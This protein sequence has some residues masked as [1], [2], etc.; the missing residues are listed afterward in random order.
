M[1]VSV[2]TTVESYPISESDSANKID[3]VSHLDSRRCCK[4]PLAEAE[5]W[6][7]YVI[8][9]NTDMEL[10]WLLIKLNY[11]E[12]ERA[13]ERSTVLF[14]PDKVHS[15]EIIIQWSVELSR[16]RETGLN[17]LKLL[18]WNCSGVT[19]FTFIKSIN[20]SH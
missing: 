16:R 6:S 20:I 19:Q 11:R 2:R 18:T 17:S 14:Q 12:G 5:V 8:R 10:L 9:N 13:L 3:S 1:S 4:H 15:W 7:Y